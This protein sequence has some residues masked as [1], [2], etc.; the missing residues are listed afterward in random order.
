MAVP[1]MDWDLP[2]LEQSAGEGNLCSVAGSPGGL[3][4][5]FD[6][7]LGGLGGCGMAD[8]WKEQRRPFSMPTE[9]SSAAAAAGS[10]LRRSRGPSAA[11]GQNVLCLV[12]GCIS[13]LG[14]CREY[15]R[16]HKVCEVHSKTPVVLVGG[17]ERRFCQQCSRFH[18]LE[19]FDEVKRSCRKRLDG[20]NRRRRKSQPDSIISGNFFPNH[21]TRFSSCPQVLSNAEADTTWSSTIKNEQE[22]PYTRHPPPI[23]FLDGAPRPPQHPSSSFTRS[24]RGGQQ[25][26]FPHG[27]DDE[28]AAGIGRTALEPAESGGGKVIFTDGLFGAFDSDCALSLLSSSARTPDISIGLD[29]AVDRIPMG[30]PVLQGLEYGSGLGRYSCLKETSNDVSTAFL[31]SE[32]EDENEGSAL[33]SDAVMEAEI[34]CQQRIFHVGGEGHNSDGASQF[35]PFAW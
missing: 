17:Q 16:R 3:H 27:N 21:G 5:S 18:M 31:C 22:S 13:D 6:L 29:G 10:Q 35:F 7:N 20:H 32:V 34:H 1:F 14:H 11:A 33:I 19:E 12:D 9:M 23:H 2:E 15:H 8:S 4:C 28:P 25:F 24:F 30:Q 26:R